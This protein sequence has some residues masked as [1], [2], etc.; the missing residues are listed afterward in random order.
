LLDGAHNRGGAEALAKYLGGWW[1]TGSIALVFAAMN[2]KDYESILEVLDPVVADFIFT[3]PKNTRSQSSTE[4]ADS[5][6]GVL[7]ENRVFAVK[8]VSDALDAAI[9]LAS[10]YPATK[11]ALVLVTGSLYLVGEVR[12]ILTTEAP[13]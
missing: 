7:G 5:M 9:E 13:E 1:A 3:E 10:T 2:D 6:R 8:N 12:R 11:P 4:M